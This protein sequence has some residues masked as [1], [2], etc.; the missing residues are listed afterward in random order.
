MAENPR[1]FAAD[2]MSFLESN[3]TF[4]ET[5]EKI[6]IK[7]EHVDGLVHALLLL[8]QDL[9]LEKKRHSAARLSMASSPMDQTT[10]AVAESPSATEVQSPSP[11][12]LDTICNSIKE[13]TGKCTTPDCTKE[14]PPDCRDYLRCQPRRQPDCH[15]WHT[16]VPLSIHFTNQENAR[17]HKKE[18]I[19]AAKAKVTQRSIRTGNESR[20]KKPASPGRKAAS[21]QTDNRPPPRPV[22]GQQFRRRQ[23]HQPDRRSQHRPRQQATPRDPRWNCPPLTCTRA[24]PLLPSMRNP[25]APHSTTQPRP[26]PNVAVIQMLHEALAALS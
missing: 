7:K 24:Y 2:L 8:S 14:H 10:P 22:L 6:K 16:F 15:L 20:W 3:P 4:E 11:K 26:N 13:R 23:V 1:E 12:F 21:R 17:K 19:K 9:K 5:R 25:I 18:M